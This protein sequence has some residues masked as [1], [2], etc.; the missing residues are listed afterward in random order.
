LKAI[1]S[2]PRRTDVGRLGPWIAATWT[3]AAV[4]ALCWPARLVGPLDGIPFDQPSDAIV[5]GLL[6]PSLWWL[7]RRVAG[8]LAARALIAAL[9]LWKVGGSVVLQ[10]QGLCAAA[11]APAPWSGTTQTIRVAEPSGALRSWDVRADWRDPAPRC[12]AIL[13]RALPESRDFPAWFVNIT[14]QMFGRRDVSMTVDGFVTVD[15]PGV[16]RWNASSGTSMDA[17]A[18][19]LQRG[20]QAVSY[21]WHLTGEDWRFVPQ[22]D[23]A[24]LWQR[25]IV[26][27]AEPR[28]ID[29]WVAPW[30]SAV[31]PLLVIAMVA[32]MLVNLWR[33]MRPAPVMIAASLVMSLVSVLLAS[34]G[35]LAARAAGLVAVAAC[36]IPVQTHLRNL[37]GAFLLI[38]A[39]WLVFFAAWSSAQIGRFSVYSSDDWLAYQ[40]AGYRIVMNGY[41]LEAGTLTFDYQPLYRWITGVLHVIFGDS[42]VGEVYLDAA[43]LLCGALLAFRLVRARAGFRWALVASAATLA[44]FTL[45]TTW[46]FVGRGLSEIAAA[47]WA[48]VAVFFILRGRR[49]SAGWMVAAS[50]ATVLMV[51]TRLNHLLWAPCLAAFL[52]PLRAPARLSALPPALAQVRWSRLAILAAVVAAGILLLPLRTWYYTGVFSMFYGTSL[53]H[54]DTRLR[55]RTLFDRTV[56]EKIAHSLASF[57]TVSEPPRFDPRALVM[58][59][60]TLAWLATVIQLPP[61]RV[62]PAAVVIAAAGAV[63]GAFFAHAHPYP[64]RFSIHAVPFASALAFLAVRAMVTRPA[65][66]VAAISQPT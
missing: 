62:V 7:D 25:A 1:L 48:F 56:W 16:L 12:T 28:A 37:R 65:P 30:G 60:G 2:D 54:N 61:A 17:A 47:G 29:R 57:V 53:R 42:S 5:I 23:G 31:A 19:Y 32:G 4:A 13:T 15:E 45:S 44:T 52:L 18:Q 58:G 24:S 22:I 41:W 9:L 11:Y 50:I 43:A 10:Q 35:S 8:R 20:S 38:G 34:S 21:S 14:D 33:Q 51:Y 36:V 3:I 64:G 40:V 46:H 26:T 66:R 55:L 49:G 59:A 27:T 6:I 63:V 39:P